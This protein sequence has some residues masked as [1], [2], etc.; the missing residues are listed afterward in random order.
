MA[1]V[2]QAA[3]TQCGISSLHSAEWWESSRS[4]PFGLD[5]MRIDDMR[6]RVL[7]DPLLELSVEFVLRVR[8]SE[9]PGIRLGS[10]LGPLPLSVI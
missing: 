3:L 2:A 10:V 5:E 4:E 6:I 9:T 8:Q 7:G 1:F